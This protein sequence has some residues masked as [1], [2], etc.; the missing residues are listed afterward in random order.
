MSRLHPYISGEL[1]VIVHGN[2][3]HKVQPGA[4]VGEMIVWFG[5]VRQATLKASTSGVMATLMLGELQHAAAASRA[6]AC[7]PQ[8]Y[9]C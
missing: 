3:V 2:A 5:G 6:P 4:F 8:P 7:W 9:T 1:D